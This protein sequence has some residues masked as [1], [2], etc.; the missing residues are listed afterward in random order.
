MMHGSINIRLVCLFLLNIE[1]L[2]Y[3]VP[4]V[5]KMQL[6]LHVARNSIYEKLKT[7]EVKL[8]INVPSKIIS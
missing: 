8:R 4:S 7:A 1:A 2:P 5:A 3:L 6:L